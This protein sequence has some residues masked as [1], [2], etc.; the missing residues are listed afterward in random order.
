MLS[1]SL[2]PP[3]CPAISHCLPSASCH[4]PSEAHDRLASQGNTVPCIHAELALAVS[5]SPLAESF[6]CCQRKSVSIHR[7]AGRSHPSAG[8]SPKSCSP[9]RASS[10][11]WHAITSIGSA[12]HPEHIFASRDAYTQAQGCCTTDRPSIQCALLTRSSLRSATADE[13]LRV[14]WSTLC[15][16]VRMSVVTTPIRLLSLLAASF[17]QPRARASSSRHRRRQARMRACSHRLSSLHPCFRDHCL[18]DRL[19][20]DAAVY[21][22]EADIPVHSAHLCRG[23]ELR[24]AARSSRWSV[25][26]SRQ[27]I[28][29]A[30]PGGGGHTFP[31]PEAEP[32]RFET[33][34]SSDVVTY[35]PTQQGALA[36]TPLPLPLPAQRR[37][38]DEEAFHE[39]ESNSR[40][41]PASRWMSGR[42]LRAMTV[43]RSV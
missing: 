2:A 17:L 3:A 34:V 19:A 7:L 9:S 10:L 42:D 15:E 29:F 25:C 1:L 26:S 4:L 13:E 11:L 6:L 27:C 23:G 20:L 24:M 41:R 35:E 28:G 5:H 12:L 31:I 21:P 33:R 37:A 16:S 32:A 18:T 22:H 38:F 14:D 43:M 8:F 39:R 30:C 40:K 36:T